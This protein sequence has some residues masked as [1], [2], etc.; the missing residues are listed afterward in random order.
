MIANPQ[1]HTV[2]IDFAPESHQSVSTGWYKLPGQG[3]LVRIYEVDRNRESTKVRYAKADG[4]TDT[5]YLSNT[6]PVYLK[7][8]LP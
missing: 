8:I 3:A 6:D 4:T 2:K 1:T 5:T 7:A